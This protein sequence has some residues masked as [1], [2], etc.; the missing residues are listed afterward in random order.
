RFVEAV[1]VRDD[2]ADLG[3]AGAGVDHVAI[4]AGHGDGADGGAAQEA[5]GD[6]APV[7][8]AVDALPDA[9]GAGAEVEGHRLDRIARPGDPP[10]AARRAD[11][12]PFERVKLL[13]FGETRRT[14]HSRRFS[15]L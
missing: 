8:A 3:L 14:V 11:A 15:P 7:D 6:A 2:E 1:A 9:A 12:P 13:G 5:V 10:T 4:A